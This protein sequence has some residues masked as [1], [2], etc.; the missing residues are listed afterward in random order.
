MEKNYV[1]KRMS[2]GDRLY[3]GDVELTPE[4]ALRICENV[5]L[6]PITIMAVTILLDY[7]TGIAPDAEALALEHY[8]AFRDKF[9]S[10]KARGTD[11]A[12]GRL[13]MFGVTAKEIQR[14]HSEKIAGVL[15]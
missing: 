13:M 15:R 9:M 6:D 2:D 14:W 12:M 5:E 8:K 10:P 4:A 11:P 3:R 1:V 7:F